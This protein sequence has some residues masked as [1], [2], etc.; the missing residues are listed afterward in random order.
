MY[1]LVA[2]YKTPQN[3]DEFEKHYKEIHTPITLKIPKMK[4]VRVNRV[5]G[6][7]NGKPEYYMQA[8]LCFETKED[9]KEAMKSKE[10]MLSGKDLMGFAGDIVSVHFMEENK[11]QIGPSHQ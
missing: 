4:E 3:T 8:E 10:A 6:A 2:L 9:F 11:T 7:P 1:K 5:F